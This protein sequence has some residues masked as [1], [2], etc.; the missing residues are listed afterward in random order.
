VSNRVLYPV[1]LV[2]LLGE[3]TPRVLPI[4]KAGGDL[5]AGAQVQLL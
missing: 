5:L 4:G 3:S 2:D 1:E